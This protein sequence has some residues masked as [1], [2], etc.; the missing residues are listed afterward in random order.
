M[1]HA[2]AFCNAADAHGFAAQF[3]L[4][5][6][7]LADGVGGHDGVGCICAA[8]GVQQPGGFRGTLFNGLNGKNLANDAGGGH[9]DV[10]GI[11]IQRLSGD[12]AHP[13]CLFLTVSI[14]GIGIAAVADDGLSDAILQVALGHQNGRALDFV[15]G[16]DTGSVTGDRAGDES[17]IPLGLVAPDAA[18]NACGG[19]PL[20]G[21]DAAI[22]KCIGHHE[23]SLVNPTHHTGGSIGGRLSAARFSI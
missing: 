7:F 15:E 18:V 17:Q 3:Q 16:I 11:Q 10:G 13:P 19:K 9:N 23:T 1:N 21:G 14:A 4:Y 6:H 8:K 12:F 22:D 5:R 20:C 2:A